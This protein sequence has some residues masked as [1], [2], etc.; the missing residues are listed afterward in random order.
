M[1]DEILKLFADYLDVRLDKGVFTTEDSVRY[2]FFAAMLS[3]T[4][5]RPED[6]IQ[7]YPHAPNSNAKV[8]TYVP[9]F[10]GKGLVAEFKYHRKIPSRSATPHPMNAG[11][12][13]H[14]IYRLKSFSAYP[15]G[16][17][18]VVYLTDPEMV[19]YMSRARNRLDSFFKLERGGT[20]N[21][22][23]AF[24]QNKCRTFQKAVK[25]SFSAT[26]RCLLSVALPQE[27][28]LRVYAVENDTPTTESIVI[29]D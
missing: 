17:R 15:C 16:I 11:E 2:T 3:A 25:V 7:E 24:L 4:D 22:D 20:M 29:I 26:L 9:D 12:L 6:V 23:P 8:D 14:D 13:F 19:G 28:H 18:V 1:L 21:I 27:H 10:A 5:L